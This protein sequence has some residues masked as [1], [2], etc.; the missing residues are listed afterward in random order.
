MRISKQTR[1]TK[2]TKIELELNIDGNSKYEISTG[3]KFFDHMLEQFAHHGG[4]DLK[5]KA[6]SLDS[7]PH[8]CVED[9]GLTLGQ[10]FKEAL[11]DKRGI[12]R[13]S[14][15]ILPMDEALVL[16]AIDI[17]GRPFC[18]VKMDLKD[19]KTSDFETVLLPHFFNSFAQ[20]AGIT[21]H[22]KKFDGTDTH[23]IIEASFKSTARALKKACFID[24]NKI[25]E[26][27]S[28]KGIL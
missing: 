14:S 11:G 16:S 2:E 28:T 13:Y 15:M 20:N 26:I 8:H 27:P 12:I 25:N 19:E 10:A 7:D 9:V 24:K 18:S 4:F 17:S 3:I 5:I 6:N 1:E 23:H 22:I 21:L